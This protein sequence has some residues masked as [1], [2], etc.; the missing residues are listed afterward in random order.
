MK[1]YLMISVI[2]CS[3]TTAC[4]TNSGDTSTTI[5]GKLKSCLTE[6]SWQVLMNGTLGTQGL[7]TTAKSISETCLKNLAL[8]HIGLENQTTQMATTILSALQT[9]SVAQ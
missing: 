8:E 2:I 5:T 1:K 7:S 9:Q 4:A 3:L 6:Q